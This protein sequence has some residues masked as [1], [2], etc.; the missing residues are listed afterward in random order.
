[1]RASSEKHSEKK[2]NRNLANLIFIAL[3]LHC[4]LCYSAFVKTR[5]EVDFMRLKQPI[6]KGRLPEL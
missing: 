3:T 4:A 2:E 1:M 6:W 5:P